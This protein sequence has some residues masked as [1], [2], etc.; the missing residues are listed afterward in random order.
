MV[1]QSDFLLPETSMLELSVFA[2]YRFAGVPVDFEE[3]Q[4]THESDETDM[5][6]TLLAIKRNGV[7]LKGISKYF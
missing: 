3:V 7:C 6:N 1:G 5:K 4:L 2:C